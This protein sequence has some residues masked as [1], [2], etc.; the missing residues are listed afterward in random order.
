MMLCTCIYICCM[1]IVEIFET[2]SHIFLD[3]FKQARR[4]PLK[5][6]E[7]FLYRNFLFQMFSALPIIPLSP[8]ATSS[9]ATLRS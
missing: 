1:N 4:Q 5:G 9:Q 8:R 3:G 7:Q 2:F 6:S